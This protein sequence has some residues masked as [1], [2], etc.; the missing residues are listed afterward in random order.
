M[1][2]PSQTESQN[3]A[4]A[5]RPIGVVVLSLLLMNAGWA[6]APVPV[7]ATKNPKVEE[8]TVTLSPFV[9]DA[10]KDVGYRATSTLAGSRSA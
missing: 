7:D 4:R 9:V 3:R 10:S 6:Q 1:K 8:E 2:L 5:V